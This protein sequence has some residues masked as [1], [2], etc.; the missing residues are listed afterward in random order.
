MVEIELGGNAYRIGKMNAFG[1][2]HVS[3][4]LAPV[5]PALIPVMSSVTKGELATGRASDRDSCGDVPM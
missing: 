2:F 1:Q 4:K 3:R 5:V